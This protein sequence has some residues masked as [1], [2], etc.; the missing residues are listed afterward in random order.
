MISEKVARLKIFAMQ[1]RVFIGWNELEYPY[2]GKFSK[3]RNSK[4]LS[5]SK[6]F[7]NSKK[8]PK[9]EFR[10]FPISSNFKTNFNII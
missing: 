8:V 6:K 3:I 5:N 2:L 4:Y 9:S 1:L 7:G 10:N